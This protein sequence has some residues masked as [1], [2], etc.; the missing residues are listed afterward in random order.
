VREETGYCTHFLRQRAIYHDN[1]LQNL[2]IST[3]IQRVLCDTKSVRMRK[4]EAAY[5]AVI[6]NLPQGIALEYAGKFVESVA[7]VAGIHPSQS[8]LHAD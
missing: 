5:W 7:S 6:M 1:W 2:L 8:L 4:F 3:S